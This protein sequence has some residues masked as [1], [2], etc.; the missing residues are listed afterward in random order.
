MRAGH[1]GEPA[2]L[3]DLT[4]AATSDKYRAVLEA[5]LALP[6]CDA[7]LA[8]VGSSAQFHPE[9]AVKPIVGIAASAKPLAVFLAPHAEASLK[10]LAEAGVPAFR[11][12]EACAD[13]LAAYFAWR[14]PR[15]QTGQRPLP[16]PRP[17]PRAA[18]CTKCRR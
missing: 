12:P 6:D 5:L 8:V 10:L 11:T 1:C 17:C 7:V 18:R 2:P 4:L 14:A 9:L 15:R 16:G 13:A 3:I